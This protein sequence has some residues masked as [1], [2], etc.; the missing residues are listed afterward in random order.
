MKQDDRVATFMWNSQPHL[1]VYLAAPYM[2]AVLH[3]LN[4]RLFPEQLTYIVN[5]ARDKVI[6][7]DDS[8]IPLLAQVAPSSSTSS[9]SSWSATAMRARCR[10][11]F[12]TR[13]CWRRGA[14]LRLAR[15]GRAQAAGLCYTSGTTG[16]PKGVLYSHRS[17]ILHC[18]A[19][20]W[21]TRSAS[22]RPTG[23]CPWCRCST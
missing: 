10:T 11:R 9:T 19:T 12:A 3:M 2:G 13:S 18:I 21:P 5:H 7:V 6:F 17:N 15:A 4:I 1:E 14:G 23:C 22:R 16:N 20:G 8:L